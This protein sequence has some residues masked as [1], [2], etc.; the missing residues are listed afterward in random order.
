[1][2]CVDFIIVVTKKPDTSGWTEENDSY[3]IVMRERQDKFVL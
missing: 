1:M 2:L 3:E